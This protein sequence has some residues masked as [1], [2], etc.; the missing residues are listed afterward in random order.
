MFS[1]MSSTDSKML[2]YA[3]QIAGQA[4]AFD[5]AKN[6]REATINYIK[7]AE[8]LVECTKYTR[9]ANMKQMWSD[10]AT[11]Y[12]DRAEELKNMGK[13]KVR[14]RSSS[15]P[16]TERKEGEEPE[17]EEEEEELTEEELEMEKMVMGTVLIEKPDTSWEDIAG[18]PEP[19][20]ALREAVVLP[21]LRPNLFTGA[22]KP[23]SGILLFGPPGCG[24]TMLAKAAANEIKCTFFVADSA[25]IMSK[26]LGESEKL[27]RALFDVARRKAPSIVFF[28]EIDSVAG[29]RGGGG[30][31]GG[32]RRLKTQ[33]LQE[34]Q[35][36]K[37]G[38]SDTKKL[39]T[40]M[41]ATNRPWDLD[42]AFLRRFERKIYTP[43]PDIESREAIFA[44][45]TRGI[46][47]EDS[48]DFKELAE[49]TEGYSGSDIAIVCREVI[50]RPIR[51]LDKSGSLEGNSDV[52]VRP[53]TRE[54]FD[55][56]LRKIRPTV[57][58]EEIQRFE[59]WREEYGG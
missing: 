31:G 57:S 1:N 58:D 41:A 47:K 40:I 8:I 37:G 56:A 21:L 39:L 13:K 46:E 42:S 50:M 54:D 14:L 26:W 12:L 29:T 59:D 6:Y 15:K 45:H 53:I 36:V 28:D 2:K 32:E 35:G 4:I 19:K 23:W 7:A 43:L 24:K 52:N 10:K 34:I 16:S 22:R 25:S 20:Q 44:Y 18:L 5:R 30:E 49:I 17:E 9:N 27:V 48:V 55:A 3:K 51:E 11:E 38:G 33:L